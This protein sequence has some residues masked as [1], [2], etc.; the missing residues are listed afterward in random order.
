MFRFSHTLRKKYQKKD[1]QTTIHIIVL[2][3]Q[4]YSTDQYF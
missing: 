4:V 2:G 1:E 3:S